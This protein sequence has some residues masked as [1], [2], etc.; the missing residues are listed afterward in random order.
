MLLRWEIYLT[1]WLL[2]DGVLSS[3]VS[4]EYPCC[5]RQGKGHRFGVREWSGARREY[6][7]VKIERVR[8]RD[9]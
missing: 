9:K 2:R 4:N 5:T 3:P 8:V 6:E 1:C 7:Y